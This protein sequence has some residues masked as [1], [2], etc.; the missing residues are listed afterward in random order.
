MKPNEA[1][2]SE[3]LKQLF[4]KHKINSCNQANKCCQMV[5]VQCFSL[6]ENSG[7]NSKYNQSN[8][9][10]NHFQLHQREWTAIPDKADTIRRYLTRIFK[11]CN[12]PTKGNHT[13][14]RKRLDTMS[15][16]IV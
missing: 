7:K 15:N 8:H 16:K 3:W 11:K 1:S 9:L 5:P 12:N 2:V 10:L 13:Y 4:H 6:K 14:Q